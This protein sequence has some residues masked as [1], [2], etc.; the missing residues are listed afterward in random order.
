MH[1]L[2]AQKRHNKQY[3][4]GLHHQDDQSA[5]AVLPS[6]QWW[7]LDSFLSI[8]L[9][10][11]CQTFDQGGLQ[12]G[13]PSSVWRISQITLGCLEWA[14]GESK[15]PEESADCFG[16]A[17]IE[18]GIPRTILKEQDYAGWSSRG[19]QTTGLLGTTSRSSFGLQ[20]VANQMEHT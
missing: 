14:E 7:R 6:I 16:W 11:T 9:E 5:G 20:Q 19:F 18:D 2:Y 8:T 13:E 10:E 4:L 17:S 1:H 12:P 15:D 3:N